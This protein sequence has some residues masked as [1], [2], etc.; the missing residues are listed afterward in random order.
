MRR[1]PLALSAALT[2]T[3]LLTAVSCDDRPDD[4]V[5]GEVGL[6]D[7][8][9]VVDA[10]A[11]VTATAAATLTAVADGTLAELWV[12][13][14]ERVEEG[15]I[16]AV[17]DSPEAER[18][19]AQADEA[20]ALAEQASG[21]PLPAT[22]DL[23]ATQDATD[24]AA[25]E[26]FD[27][28]QAAADRI[29]DERLREALL[30][31]V[32]LAERRYEAAAEAARA[33]VDAVQAG[34]ASLA[35][36]VSAMTEA[37]RVQAQ[38]AYDLAAATV[39]ELT[40]RAPFDGVVQLGGV[41]GGGSPDALGDLL[42]ELGELPG[43]VPELPQ[44]QQP[45]PGVDP[46]LATGS[47]VTAGTPVLTVVDVSELRLLAEVD[48]TDVLLVEPGVDAEVELDAAPGARYEATVT[49][50]DLLPTPSDRGG[51]A[52]RVRLDLGDGQLPDGAPAPPPRP[53]M[54]A[55]AHLRVA[56]A[57]GV[58]AVPAAAILRVDGTD[59]VWLVRDGRAVR[60]PVTVGVQ[61]PELVEIVAGL[62]P[63]DRIVVSGADLVSEGDRV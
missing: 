47:P 8:V 26:A 4:V 58:V 43:G 36:A 17:I 62:R 30:A 19:L 55:V 16:L 23:S 44:P 50:V 52:Y 11:T 3:L 60:T 21:S 42:G 45:P 56:E 63:G 7:V 48:E 49:A 53:G 22:A 29:A 18:R 31:Q 20:L 34:V 25:A 27:Q 57:T 51:V 14:G 6:A 28:A 61:G 37:Q 59:V 1:A 24:D 40:L 12:E 33:A 41:P 46:A 39:D 15:D 2:V 5:V 35:T 9:E 54:S 10:P 32:E 13:P 38:Q